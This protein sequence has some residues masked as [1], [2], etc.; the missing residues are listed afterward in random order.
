MSPPPLH[1]TSKSR[2]VHD[3]QTPVQCAAA[4]R[5][6]AARLPGPQIAVQS[7]SR[8]RCAPTQSPR[9][10]AS[11]RCAQF[12]AGGARLGHLRVSSPR[13]LIE[14]HAAPRVI[15]TG[16]AAA[17]HRRCRCPADEQFGPCCLP[18]LIAVWADHAL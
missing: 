10:L 8:G 16:L 1:V 11:S 18:Y 13:S 2:D 3:H 17:V 7:H 6:E 14:P 4:R 12:A 15:S 5:A 9:S